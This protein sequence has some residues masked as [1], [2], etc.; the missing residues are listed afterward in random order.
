MIICSIK[1]QAVVNDD[2]LQ[3]SFILSDP[4]KDVKCNITEETCNV[5]QPADAFEG[6]CKCGESDSCTGNEK[7]SYC[8][9][10]QSLC[11]CAA[12]VDACSEGHTCIN[13]ECKG[14]L[15][16]PYLRNEDYDC[17]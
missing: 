12:T 14:I 15:N 11:K 9:E 8:D 5:V 1:L 4:C 17:F 16:K 7:G 10:S 13:G 6:V 2:D 3:T